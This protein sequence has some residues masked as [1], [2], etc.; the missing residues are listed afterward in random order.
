[1][2]KTVSLILLTALLFT[3][4]GCEQLPVETDPLPTET[5]PVT[6][7]LTETDPPETDPPETKPPIQISDVTCDPVSEWKNISLT[8][9]NVER[10]SPFPSLPILS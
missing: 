5:E 10:R 8:W 2:K 1:M 3:F 9:K 6:E 4:V 7:S